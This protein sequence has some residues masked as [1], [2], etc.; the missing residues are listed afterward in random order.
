MSELI[1]GSKAP[2]IS[3]K[4]Q[5][6]ESIKL[7]D[8]LGKKV[9]LFFYPE[10]Q[11]PTCTIEA[12]NLRDNFS[13]LK[14]RGIEIIGIS[15]DD[16]AKHLKFIDKYDLQ[17]TLLCDPELKAMNAYGTWG[18]KNM[19]GRKYMGVLRTTFLINEDGKIFDVIKKVRSADHAKQILDKWGL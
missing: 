15:P 19:Y 4:N 14:R 6:G 7:K 16:E 11:T 1:K 3:L 12:C 17:Y 9:A 10:D 18:E 8:Y 13:S 2:A 5:H